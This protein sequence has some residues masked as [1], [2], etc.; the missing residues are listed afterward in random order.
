ML[1]RRVCQVRTELFGEDGSARLAEVLRIPHRTWMNYEAGVAIPAMVI[2][3]L[4][5]ACEVD[6]RWLL[7]GEG[8]MIRSLGPTPGLA[9]RPENKE[10]AR[11]IRRTA[12]CEI[13]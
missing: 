12:G 6:S 13:H 10:P 4:I 2:L 7:T 3:R 9:I 5:L 8:R 1:A 11:S